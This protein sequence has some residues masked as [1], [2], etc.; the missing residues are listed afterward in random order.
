MSKISA[1][2][3]FI[4]AQLYEG[5]EWFV[6]Y[7][8]FNPVTSQLQRKKVKI[9]RIRSIVERRKYAQTVIREINSKLHSGWNP[10]LE[11]EAPKGFV[12]L[13][14]AMNTF[15][16]SKERELRPDSLRSYSSYIK[17]LNAYL[18]TIDQQKIF[19][20]NF[21]SSMAMSFMNEMYNSKRLSTTTFNNYRIF[22]LTLWN[23]LKENE[24][25]ASNA[26]SRIKK[27]KAGE[28]E[29][30][31][32]PIPVRDLVKD[33]LEATDYNFLICCLLVFH[34]LLRPKE[35]CWLKPNCFFLAEQTI[36]VTSSSAKNGHLRT[37]TI[38][39]SLMPFLVQWDF[40]RAA[41]EE[42]IF[43]DGML[44]GK[45]PVNPREWSRKW[46]N[47]RREL[48]IPAPMKLYSLRDTGIVQ[49]LRDGVSPDDVMRHADHSS[50]A[51]TSI[52]LRYANL[53]GSDQIRRKGSAF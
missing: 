43:S 46:S 3:S 41:S 13:S 33:H 53:S 1:I 51:V 17:M 42:F 40:N 37:A 48:K 9:N 14:A 39:D 11:E 45:V 52:Y 31:M 38:P 50:L 30:I 18:A 47:M 12:L 36:R 6:G 8:C 27:K 44:P 5:K 7:Y 35:I 25:V 10:F 23:W 34:S 20:V 24:Y 15:F 2:I 4:P 22:F 28:K 32:I 26:F 16:R 49:L 29:R 19:A 21:T